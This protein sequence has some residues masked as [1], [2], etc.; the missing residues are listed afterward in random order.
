MAS[1][2]SVSAL[3]LVSSLHLT[4]KR[5]S[6]IHFVESVESQ[7]AAKALTSA[8]NL[9]RDLVTASFRWFLCTCVNDNRSTIQVYWGRRSNI[10][11]DHV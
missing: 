1:S 4:T 7:S 10:S 6:E 5:T 11:A 3:C 8:V 2:A 9:A